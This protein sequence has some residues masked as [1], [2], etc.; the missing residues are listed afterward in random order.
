MKNAIFGTIEAAIFDMDGTLIDSM[1]MWHS[2]AELYLKS[3]GK[4]PRGNLWNDVKWLNMVETAE[5]FISE[6]NVEKTIP[7]I[8]HGVEDII[9]GFYA[10]KLTP[11]PGAKELLQILNERAVPCVLATATERKCTELCMERLGFHSYFA[12]ILTCLDFNTSKSSP[13]IFQ[14]AAEA[15][16]TS[17]EKTIVFEDALH[18][19]RSAR[20]AGFK[21]CAV[22]DPSAEEMTEP[23][24][25]DWHRI[26]PL[27]DI[28]CHS[29]EKIV[30]MFTE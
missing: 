14:K 4:T 16:G 27:S 26:I 30:N 15:C 12:S 23:P 2:I 8:E 13:L 3:V 9:L 10:E 7:E 19:I 6:Y 21:I 17:P 20:G 22:Y 5:Y 1:P 24:E 11:K 29:L 28:Q 18:A 25:T